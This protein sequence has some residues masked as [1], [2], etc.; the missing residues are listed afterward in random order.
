MCGN[1][2]T[3]YNCSESRTALQLSVPKTCFH[4]CSVH[5]AVAHSSFLHSQKSFNEHQH[6]CLVI[7]K[8]KLL[9]ITA[10][11]TGSF[12]KYAKNSAHLAPGTPISHVPNFWG[13]ISLGEILLER[14]VEWALLHPSSPYDGLGSEGWQAEHNL[15]KACIRTAKECP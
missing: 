3:H 1:D 11:G 7:N 6:I 4:Q 15:R 5:Q 10:Q 13:Q 2:A 14:F 12:V 9:R 8:K